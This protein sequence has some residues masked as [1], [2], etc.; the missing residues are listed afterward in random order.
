MGASQDTTHDAEARALLL[1]QY[2]GLPGIQGILDTYVGDVQDLE[3]ALWSLGTSMDIFS[4]TGVQLD[5]WGNILNQPRNGL[6]DTPYQ[7]VLLAKIAQNVSQGTPEDVI[8][9]Y[10]LLMNASYVEYIETPDGYPAAFQI[11][12]T[13][14]TPVT[15]SQSIKNAI[16]ATKAA[17]VAVAFYAS[18]PGPAFSFLG[19][20]DPTGQGFA[21]L[22]NPSVGGT[23]SSIF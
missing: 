2:K 4:S 14:A 13:G 20:P 22:N 15:D 5:M 6:S 17:G 1:A 11:T 19:D 9:V 18:I 12:A 23:L 7:G 3:N 21:D 8:R 16:N 10:K